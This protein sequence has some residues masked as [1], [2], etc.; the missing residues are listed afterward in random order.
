MNKIVVYYSM[1]GNTDY[2]AEKIADKTGADLLRIDPVKAYP[3]KGFMKFYRGG[4]SAV[5]AQKPQLLPYE[6]H[7]ER[8]DLI[9]LG[10]P[11]WA[12]TFSPPIR[13]FIEENRASFDGKQIAAYLCCSGSGDKALEKLKKAI[14][15][16]GFYA[17][18]MFI[19]P[20]QHVDNEKQIADF[21]R[22]LD[23]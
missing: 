17:E 18:A 3:D 22:K 2:V 8:Y 16:E 19:D 13:T 23:R 21:C 10:S 7:P 11:V 1:L 4:K 6:F 5:M 14:G 9:I 20:K 15:I 12:S